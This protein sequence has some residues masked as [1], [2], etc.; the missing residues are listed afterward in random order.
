MI[1]V[2]REV[3][4]CVAASAG[5]LRVVQDATGRPTVCGVESNER[6]GGGVDDLHGAG[7]IRGGTAGCDA[8]VGGW[9]WGWEGE[10][11]RE[12]IGG[13]DRCLVEGW[14]V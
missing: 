7:G 1:A 9:G 4:C 5:V 6:L 2:V 11:E 10:G 14:G 8:L 12:G 3:C 13:G